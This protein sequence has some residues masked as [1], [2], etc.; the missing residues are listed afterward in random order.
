MLILALFGSNIY[1][2]EHLEKAITPA[3]GAHETEKWMN[4]LDLAAVSKMFRINIIVCEWLVEE[5]YRWQVYSPNLE[6]TVRICL[7]VQFHIATL[8]FESESK[9]VDCINIFILS[10]QPL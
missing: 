3:T 4:N 9:G 1:I 6:T 5:I 7:I 8:A 10:P 2:R